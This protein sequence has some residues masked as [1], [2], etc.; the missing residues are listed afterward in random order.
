MKKEKEAVSQFNRDVIDTGGYLYA[1]QPSL[2]SLLANKRLTVATLEM[3]D[4]KNKN[5]M[6]VGC[7]DGVYTNELYVCGRPKLIVGTDAAGKAVAQAKKKYEKENQKIYFKT[8]S[9]YRISSPDNSFD[10]AIARGLLHH[11]D[12]PPEVLKEMFRVSKEVFIIE[13]NG[14]NPL[15]KIIEKF[16]LY[17]RKH[18]EKSYP[19]L[20]IKEWVICLGGKIETNEYLGLVPF[21]CPD[22]LAILL[23]KIE[24]LIEKSFL[25]KYLCAVV[26]IKAKK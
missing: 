8:E 17:H 2:S 3:L 10:I 11:L 15:L 23:K 22:F 20:K 18:K 14:N 6:D 1:H 7:G 24:P 5:V 26:V 9:G 13:P 16:S 19:P 4:L 21:F 12:R 25:K